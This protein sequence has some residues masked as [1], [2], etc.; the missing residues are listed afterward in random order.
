[1][2]H[3]VTV[4]KGRRFPTCRHRKGISFGLA[5]AAKDV[6][7]IDPELDQASSVHVARVETRLADLVNLQGEL[8]RLI[9]QCQCCI[10]SLEV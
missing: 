10:I 5:N 7:E 2:P 6:G 9:D 4:I 8:R 3:E 1:M